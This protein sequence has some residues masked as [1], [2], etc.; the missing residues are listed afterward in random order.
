MI[1]NHLDNDIDV[2]RS[3]VTQFVNDEETHPIVKYK[4]FIFAFLLIITGLLILLLFN[5]DK[6]LGHS[7]WKNLFIP[8][9]ELR[10]KYWAMASRGDSD[11][12]EYKYRNTDAAIFREAIEGM[13]TTTTKDGKA[14]NKS[15]QFVGTD[16]ESAEKKKPTPCATDCEQYIVLKGKINDLSKYVNAVKDQKDEIKQTSDKLQEL[17]KQIEDLNKSLSPGGQVKITM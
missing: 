8:V 1:Y 2:F 17:G 13:T 9:S 12:F 5:R 6:I 14:T 15:G 16:T 11:V 7:L 4:A 10:D 3:N